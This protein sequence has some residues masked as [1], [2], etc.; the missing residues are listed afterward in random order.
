M[1]GVLNF[2]KSMA[3]DTEVHR[4]KLAIFILLIPI[5]IY[6]CTHTQI[7]IFGLDY[8]KLIFAINSNKC[9]ESGGTNSCKLVTVEYSALSSTFIPYALHFREI[10]NKVEGETQEQKDKKSFK[11]YHMYMEQSLQLWTQSSFN[12]L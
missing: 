3:R 1:P 9:R 6:A 10:C 12:W 5:N 8:R 7:L 11:W 2:V 4:R